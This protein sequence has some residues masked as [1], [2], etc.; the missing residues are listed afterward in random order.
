[1]EQ[2]HGTWGD[3]LRTFQNSS[4]L[5]T[6]LFLKPNKRC[7]WHSHKT[8]FNQFTVIKGVLGVKTENGLTKVYPKQC[9]TVPPGVMHE[10]QTYK[11]PVIV[12]EIAYVE[13]NENDIDREKLGGPL[14]E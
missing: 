4:C 1:M 13:Y 8:A 9:F 10:F 7:S 12:E 5:V 3:R 14:N 11:L 6:L 2:Q